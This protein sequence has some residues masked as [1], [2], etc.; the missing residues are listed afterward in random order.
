MMEKEDVCRA[1][2]LGELEVGGGVAVLQG[3]GKVK[4][5]CGVRGSFISG[6]ENGKWI[7]ALYC[8]EQC[9]FVRT[10]PFVSQGLPARLRTG[11]RGLMGL[12]CRTISTVTGLS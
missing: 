5:R 2:L 1:S 6:S 9:R 3:R 10:V 8:V 11:W 4:R 12:L 7:G